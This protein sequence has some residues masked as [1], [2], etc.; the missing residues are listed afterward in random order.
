MIAHGIH[1]LQAEIDDKKD[2]LSEMIDRFPNIL[3]SEIAHY[4]E[5]IDI[6]AKENAEGDI[7]VECSLWN[8]STYH[9]VIDT[10]S[11]IL[12]YHYYS[13]AIMIYTF[14]ESSLKQI[15]EYSNVKI[16]PQKK[17]EKKSKL[18]RYYDT[19]KNAHK[20]LPILE[21][22]W[23]GRASFGT[24]RN[25][26]AHEMKTQNHIAMQEYLHKQLNDAYNML[27]LVLNQVLANK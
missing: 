14:A 6:E 5:L 23:A 10:Q 15:C 17:G 18:S 13:L 12:L 19:I 7:D 11:T 16:L 3:K 2:I 1:Y 4:K 27:C 20:S 26:I 21:D 24:T 22:I 9:E 25:K 8:N